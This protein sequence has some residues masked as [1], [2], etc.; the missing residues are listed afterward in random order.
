MDR[1]TPLWIETCP[2]GHWKDRQTLQEEDRQP[3]LWRDRCPKEKSHAIE[4]R[5][6][7]EDGGAHRTCHTW[8]KGLGARDDKSRDKE[9]GSE[10]RCPLPIC[11]RPGG[12]SHQC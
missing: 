9:V 8:W 7:P 5:D 4:L 2:S 10:Y 11:P 12:S 3:V 6:P 1:Q